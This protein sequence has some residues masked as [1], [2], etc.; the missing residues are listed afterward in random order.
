MRWSGA[1]DLSV[2]RR[3]WNLKGAPSFK[4]AISRWHASSAYWQYGSNTCAWI[5]WRTCQRGREARL[6]QS[7]DSIAMH[8]PTYE[9]ILTRVVAAFF[10][11]LVDYR[12]ARLSPQT[13]P[14][15]MSGMTAA[16]ASC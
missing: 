9:R 2:R 16:R 14:L 13:P 3:E 10:V 1:E 5:L 7:A 6:G 12:A 4:P 8:T 11:R 15:F